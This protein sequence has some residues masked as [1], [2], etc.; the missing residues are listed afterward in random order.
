MGRILL[1]PIMGVGFSIENYTLYRIYRKHVTL[2]RQK[3]HQFVL[4]AADEV[5]LELDQIEGQQ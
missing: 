5:F 2:Y 1:S 3:A 4:S